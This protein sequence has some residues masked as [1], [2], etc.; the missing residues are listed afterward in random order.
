MGK[1][2][3]AGLPIKKLAVTRVSKS[4]KL[5]L[6]NQ[7]YHINGFEKTTSGKHT[8]TLKENNI[9]D[10]Y[11]VSLSQRQKIDKKKNL[12]GYIEG[13]TPVGGKIGGIAI[14]KILSKV[15]TKNDMNQLKESYFNQVF[16]E[17]FFNDDHIKGYIGLLKDTSK[18]INSLPANEHNYKSITNSLIMNKEHISDVAMGTMV[19]SFQNRDLLHTVLS[20][21]P[22]LQESYSKDSF[23]QDYYVK[24]VNPMGQLGLFFQH[25]I[26]DPTK[27]S[28]QS[29]YGISNDLTSIPNKPRLTE[30]DVKMWEN[31]IDK[32]TVHIKKM[33][34]A[35]KLYNTLLI[36][37]EPLVASELFKTNKMIELPIYQSTIIDLIDSNKMSGYKVIK[38]I[39]I[40]NDT[41]FDIIDANFVI[42]PAKKV[43]LEIQLCVNNA[44][45]NDFISLNRSMTNNLLDSY[46]TDFLNN[47]NTTEISLIEAKKTLNDLTSSF[48]NNNNDSF[49]MVNI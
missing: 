19:S 45:Q 3:R 46:N 37:L 10:Q 28:V 8:S 39:K 32:N 4:G 14:D 18:L 23:K 49:I 43:Y 25:D 41:E 9:A 21:K 29:L 24:H 30:L 1:N 26:A 15:K 35:N 47:L 34:S 6:Y 31:W 16:S 5:S 20:D 33:L 11:V 27:S 7:G 22:I 48:K 2:R 36:E 38:N 13:L 17:N 12:Q 42:D 44:T 40:D